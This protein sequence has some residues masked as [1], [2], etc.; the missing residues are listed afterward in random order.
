MNGNSYSLIL[1]GNSKR[2]TC[3]RATWMVF[4]NHQPSEFPIFGEFF[5][6]LFAVE[7]ES[8]FI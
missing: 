3:V 5:S 6:G 8:S 2:S 4:G 7:Y 1:R